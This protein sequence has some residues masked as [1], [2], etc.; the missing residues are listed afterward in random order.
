MAGGGAITM[1]ATWGYSS[2]NRARRFTPSTP[3]SS[4]AT[5]TSQGAPDRSRAS[6]SSGDEHVWR[7]P[8]SPEG[9]VP[10]APP[11]PTNSTSRPTLLPS[12]APMAR[13]RGSGIAVD[14][15]PSMIAAYAEKLGLPDFL[16][17]LVVGEY[18]D[19]DPPADWVVA[20]VKAAS[21][22]PHDTWT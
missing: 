13:K 1:R 2:R 10:T 9:S 14:R 3:G 7:N 15:V 17:G 6:A 11:P 12:A 16:D 5:P 21:L 19:P 8:S 18:R 20:E 4:A 22:N